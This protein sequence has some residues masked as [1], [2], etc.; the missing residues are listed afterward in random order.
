[1]LSFVRRNAKL[2]VEIIDRPENQHRTMKSVKVNYTVKS[3]FVSHNLENINAFMKDFRK[4][5]RADFH[6]TVYLCEDGKTFMHLST[7]ANDEIQ[8]QVLDVESFKS[9]QRQRDESGLEG[10]HKIETLRFIA[11]SHDDFA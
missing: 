1:L 8:K 7:Y 10:S 3:E 6:Y 5:N 9:F 11:A 2:G 4:L